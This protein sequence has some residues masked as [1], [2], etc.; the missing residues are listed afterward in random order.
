MQSGGVYANKA[1][2]T[3]TGGLSDSDMSHYT[4]EAAKASI[5]DRIWYDKNANGMQDSGETGV[6][7]VTVELRSNGV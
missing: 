2:V 3:A 6:A 7:G 5:G 1:T 4:V